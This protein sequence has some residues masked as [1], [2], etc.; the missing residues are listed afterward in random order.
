MQSVAPRPLIPQSRGETVPA[1]QSFSM[2]TVA[3]ESQSKATLTGRVPIRIS[4]PS[5][6]VACPDHPAVER[7]LDRKGVF[8]DLLVCCENGN[9]STSE[10]RVHLRMQL[11]RQLQCAVKARID[12]GPPTLVAKFHRDRRNAFVQTIPWIN[13]G[14]LC[15]SNSHIL[16]ERST[17]D[18]RIRQRRVEPPRLRSSRQ[19]RLAVDGIDAGV[20]P[21]FCVM[22]SGSAGIPTKSPVARSESAAVQVET[23]M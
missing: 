5:T 10:S 11:R 2:T 8:L 7:K 17:T 6:N 12:N 23:V 20:S 22:S 19:A 1:Y 3:Q 15:D 18:V 13:G 16:C 21:F 9:D 4:S 14:L